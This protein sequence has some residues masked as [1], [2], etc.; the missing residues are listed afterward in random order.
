MLIKNQTFTDDIVQ[1]DGNHFDGCTFRN[2]RMIFGAV[3]PIGLVNCGFFD[4]RWEFIGAAGQTVALLHALT[5]ASPEYGNA[6]MASTFPSLKTWLRPEIL[7]K[8]E[9]PN[10]T[11][12]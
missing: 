4:V 9:K 8:L 6:L 10:A 12:G 1:L 7:E 5:T 2:C 3:G 11:N